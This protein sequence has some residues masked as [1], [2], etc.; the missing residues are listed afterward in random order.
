M[1][2]VYPTEPSTRKIRLNLSGSGLPIPSK[3]LSIIASMRDT[4]PMVEVCDFDPIHKEF[5]I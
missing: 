1:L 2:S 3:G 4:I 5:A